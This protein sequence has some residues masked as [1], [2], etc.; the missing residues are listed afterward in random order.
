MS[1]QSEYF[2]FR[3]KQIFP[4]LLRLD[5]LNVRAIRAYE[6][7]GLKKEGV[8]RADALINGKFV[9][10]VLLSILRKEFEK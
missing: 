3:A 7:A 9:D 8:L 2:L 10:S 1:R 5:F 6:K 4:A